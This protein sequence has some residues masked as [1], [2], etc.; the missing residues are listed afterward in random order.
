MKCPNCNYLHGWDNSQ[1]KNIAGE[2][3][4]FY[5]LPINMERISSY[6]DM[7]REPVYACPHC[8]MVFIEPES[9]GEAVAIQAAKELKEAEQ[10]QKI[11]EAKKK[12]FIANGRW[13]G[14][15]GQQQHIYVCGKSKA[16]AIRI[17]EEL[18][19]TKMTYEMNIYFSQGAWG[20]PMDGIIPERGAWVHDDYWNWPPKAPIRVYP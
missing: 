20:D 10:L 12:L 17:L 2:A 15:Q 11:T 3:G 13:Q 1:L 14:K 4:N 7:D 8:G 18:S 19:G 5:R 6:D 16:D 9:I